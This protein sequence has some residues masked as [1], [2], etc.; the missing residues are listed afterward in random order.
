MKVALSLAVAIFGLAGLSACNKAQPPASAPPPDGTKSTSN[1]PAADPGA[2]GVASEEEATGEGPISL[3]E[4]RYQK[5]VTYRKEFFALTGKLLTDVGS[6]S[7]TVDGKITGLGK[8]AAAVAGTARIGEKHDSELK[9]LRA[10]YGFSEA[11]DDRLWSAVGDV[12]AAKTAEN[13]A[14]EQTLKSFRDMQAKG[15]EEKK[16]ADEYFNDLEASEKEGLE[17]ARQE[18]GPQC[19][20]ILCKHAKELHSLQMEGFQTILGSG[21]PKE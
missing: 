2:L 17:K 16:V 20:E 19:V 21:K 9:A 8:T 12:L 7:K 4:E 3:T 10:K 15:G 5:Y 13:P 11:E 6:L 18:Y 14:L 1:V